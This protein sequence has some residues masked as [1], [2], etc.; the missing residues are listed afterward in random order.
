M[1]KGTIAIIAITVAVV[2]VLG[3]FISQREAPTR[4]LDGFAQCLGEKGAKFY[5]AFWCP[6]CQAQKK[7]FGASVEKL[8]YVECSLPDGKTRTQVCIDQDIQSYPTW[9][10]AD[11]SRKTGEIPLAELSEKTG[12]E[13]PQ[14]Q[15]PS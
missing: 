1:N 12:C 10:F 3:F 5:G 13:L 4:E 11:N 15:N 2:G 8:P 7:L 9:I 6:H 14:S